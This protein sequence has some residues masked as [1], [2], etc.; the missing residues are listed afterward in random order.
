MHVNGSINNDL[1][2]F[3]DT[4]STAAVTSID[5]DPLRDLAAA[6][7]IVARS[8]AAAALL[9]AIFV[10]IDQLGFS[11]AR[12]IKIRSAGTGG[13]IWVAVILLV[14]IA[15]GISAWVA[16]QV[17]ERMPHFPDSVVYLLQAR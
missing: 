1:F 12:P 10:L 17:L 14:L 8:A 4:G 6:Y 15:G 13:P 2:I 16:G 9:I 3:D 7:S 5:P 11:A